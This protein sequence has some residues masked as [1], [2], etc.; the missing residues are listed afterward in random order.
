MSRKRGKKRDKKIKTIIGIDETNAGFHVNHPESSVV[1]TGYLSNILRANYG[2]SQNEHKGK[3]MKEGMDIN[4]AR[5]KCKDYTSKYPHFLYTLIPKYLNQRNP[6]AI[7]K[8]NAAALLVFEFFLRYNLKPQ[9]TCVILD[10]TD[11]EGNS[12]A[13]N[14]VLDLWLQKAGMDIPCR[15]KD[16]LKVPEGIALPYPYVRSPEKK[17]YRSKRK[18]DDRVVAVRKADRI[19]YFISSIHY[20]GENKKWPYRDKKVCLNN[21]EDKCVEVIEKIR[22]SYFRQSSSQKYF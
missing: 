2:S 5:I 10:E 12:E 8:G 22:D 4:K 6:I 21:L 19:G 15:Y 9:E 11:G 3:L 18:A 17:P 13:V 7:L 14:Y 16:N 20:Y 1:V